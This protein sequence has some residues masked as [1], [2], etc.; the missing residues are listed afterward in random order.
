MPT[1][2]EPT[3]QDPFSEKEEME[4]KKRQRKHHKERGIYP[5]LLEKNL[6][7]CSHSVYH[8]GTIPNILNDPLVIPSLEVYD[9]TKTGIEA[10]YRPWTAPPPP[11]TVVVTVPTTPTGDQMISQWISSA[12]GSDTFGRSWLWKWGRARIAALVHKGLYDV[13]WEATTE[14]YRN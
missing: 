1:I 6:L 11:V 5:T 12:I 3:A 4:T 2:G 13:S 14:N 7:F 8:W 10:T 9:K